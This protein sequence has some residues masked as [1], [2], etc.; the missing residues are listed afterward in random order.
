VLQ[1]YIDRGI[2]YKLSPSCGAM[3]WRSDAPEEVLCERDK[4]RRY[5]RHQLA[6][7]GSGG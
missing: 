2:G 6:M 5:W 1:R 7:A 3:T 4:N